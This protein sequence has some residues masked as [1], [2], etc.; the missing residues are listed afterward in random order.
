MAAR[1]SIT[2][3]GVTYVREDLAV[4]PA[5][6]APAPV[7]AESA[8]VSFLHERAASKIPC[9]IHPAAS[10]NRSFTPKSSGRQNHVARIS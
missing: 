3:N 1:K 6:V 4:A 7:K 8:F 2:V 10:C 9:E 5:P